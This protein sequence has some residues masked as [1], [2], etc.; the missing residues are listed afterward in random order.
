MGEFPESATAPPTALEHTQGTNGMTERKCTDSN[1]HQQ[2]VGIYQGN[3]NNN[4]NNNKHSLVVL[5]IFCTI[6]NHC[7][8]GTVLDCHFICMSPEAKLVEQ[9]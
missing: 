9:Q 1:G 3:I 6:N 5:E 7:V 8:I 2:N 4:I